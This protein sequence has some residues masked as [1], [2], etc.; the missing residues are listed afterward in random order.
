M[1]RRSGLMTSAWSNSTQIAIS[2]STHDRSRNTGSSVLNDRLSDVP[3]HGTNIHW[4]VLEVNQAS[5]CALRQ[6]SGPGRIALRP[7]GRGK[8]H[9]AN[10]MNKRL[11]G[12]R[13]YPSDGDNVRQVVESSG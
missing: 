7:L 1:V 3:R 13:T 9:A 2:P 4:Q 8:P 10:L 11:H 12:K 5:P 6:A